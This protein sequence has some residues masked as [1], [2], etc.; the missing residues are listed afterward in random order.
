MKNVINEMI[1]AYAKK[2]A[3]AVLA[4]AEHA[5]KETQTAPQSDTPQD[6]E[7]KFAALESVPAAKKSVPA[8][9]TDIAPEQAE[10]GSKA[11]PSSHSTPAPIDNA[12]SSN[13][14]LAPESIYDDN[15]GYNIP[16]I[17]PFDGFDFNLPANTV[18]NSSA[19]YNTS[20][21]LESGSE[22]MI[23]FAYEAKQSAAKAA[24]NATANANNNAA[25]AGSHGISN[26]S[27][28][29]NGVQNN[30][31]KN[32][33]TTETPAAA[34]PAAETP[35]EEA[36][37]EETITEIPAEEP[38]TEEPTA[39]EPAAEKPVEEEPATEAPIAEEA[40]AE[41]PAEE[42]IAAEAAVSI[43]ATKDGPSNG[44]LNHLTNADLLS[45]NHLRH[46]ESGTYTTADKAKVDINVDD[47]TISLHGNGNWNSTKVLAISGD[48]RDF[49]TKALDITNF[50]QVNLD[51]DEKMDGSITE[52]AMDIS[53]DGLKRGSVDTGNGKDTIHIG[54]SSNG[55]GWDQT[56]DLNTNGSADTVVIS[57]ADAASVVG[58]NAA[59][60]NWNGEYT[61]V[62]VDL[63]RGNDFFDSSSVSS[64][65]VVYAGDN[66]DTVLSGGGNDKLYGEDGND[67]LDGGSGNDLLDGGAGGD[68]LF[69]GAGNDT[70]LGGDGNDTLDGG[71][72]NDILSGGAGKDTF[73]FG[74]TSGKDTITDFDKKD[75]VQIHG[76]T[77]EQ[78]EA[79]LH[80]VG[81]DA[82]LTFADGNQLTFTGMEDGLDLH[83]FDF[84]A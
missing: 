44:S 35:A 50:V 13:S 42:P 6:A 81:Q 57:S 24:S 55:N 1:M 18:A 84:M 27:T 52:R 43:W 63:G 19:I 15:A 65:D 9:T 21:F 51:L 3:A 2:S 30:P 25:T 49:G 54:L 47:D 33:G 73:V 68:K 38:S 75:T 45:L 72:G 61:K 74:T 10:A 4:K 79:A 60:H 59:K 37:A 83:Q 5:A 26:A 14:S 29:S 17:S 82:V 48:A 11:S 39:E 67:Y 76:Y 23:A 41:E 80:I 8:K 40:A 53:I 31:V 7:L 77:Q 16:A 22:D 20:A 70:L 56:I 66:S 32:G 78:V 71:T 64:T 34:E 62:N 28:K 69:G 58:V 36:P 46:A 12:Y